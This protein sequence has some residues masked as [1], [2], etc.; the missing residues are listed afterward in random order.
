MPMK[1]QVA[2]VTGAAQG[3]G[4]ATALRF[5]REGAHLVV[6][7]IN[8]EGVKKFSQEIAAL[9]R[10]SLWFEVDV[11]NIHQIKAMVQKTATDFGR[12]DILINNAGV[13][14]QMV[15]VIEQDIQTWE[16]IVDIHLKGTYLCSKEVGA[17]MIKNNFGR[18][19]NTSSIVGLGGFPN[20]TAYGPAKSAII[21]L[22]KVLAIE[23]AAFN[24]NVNA[25]APG[26]IR[27]QMNEDLIRSGKFDEKKIT[28][29]IP[30]KRMGRVE[31]VVNVVHFLCSEAASYITGETI[32]V[33]GGWVAY[34]SI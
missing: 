34:G 24:V 17:E 16:R 27:T 3:I 8:V 22:T 10:R 32:V 4:K 1:D 31:E 7:D 26:Y 30:M 23:W 6:C 25:I 2:I 29:R 15:P 13:A 18:I 28:Q 20:R 21:N 14:D 9:G 33:D 5:A 12:I 19:V 11:T